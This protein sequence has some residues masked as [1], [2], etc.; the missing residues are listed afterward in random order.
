MPVIENKSKLELKATIK[1][2]SSRFRTERQ[3]KAVT[4][5]SP[6]Q[7][8]I[9]LPVFEQFLN[10]KKEENKANK[11][12]PNNGQEGQLKTSTDKLLFML[13]YLKCYPSFDV[14]GFMFD[15][16]G[17]SASIW[18]SKLMPIFIKT[19]ADFNV[20]P[21]TKFESPEQMQEAFKDIGTL[22]IDATER[23][24]QRPQD[25]EVQKEH[26][27]G[28]KKQNT[29]KNTIITTF[30]YIVLYVG[31]TFSGKNH[32]YGM[33]KKEFDP[34]SSWF[35]SF[36]VLVDLGYLGFDKDFK[37]NNISIPHKKPRK[38]KNNPNPQLT[39][40]QKDENRAM[41]QKRVIVE[42]VIA[43][44]KR[45]KCVSDRYRNHIVELK[46]LFILLA[47]GIW[48]FNVVNRK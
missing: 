35:E 41:S 12:K 45:L 3:V 44:M 23:V 25:K 13:C 4:G 21:K 28:K 2:I 15:M 42:N 29:I 38:S 27:S 10:E 16:S 19:L 47:A 33:F 43:G 5:L 31:C 7:F 37:I 22:I 32:D 17:S 24:I 14:I 46:D 36:E 34:K 11:I 40:Q 39:Q 18:F 48:N 26:H 8:F 6:E 1:A 9:L 30:S 20:L